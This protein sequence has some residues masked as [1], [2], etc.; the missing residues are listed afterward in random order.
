MTA[1]SRPRLPAAVVTQALI[2]GSLAGKAGVAHF[3][4]GEGKRRLACLRAL[5]ADFDV[6]ARTL[7]PIHVDRS[8]PLLEEA[9][10]LAGAGAAG[11][12]DTVEDDLPRWLTLYRDLDG[13][14]SRLIVATDAHTEGAEPDQLR[15]NVAACLRE[16]VLPPE[17]VLPVVT[18]NPASA[19][20]LPRK[21]RLAPGAD[22]DVLVVAPTTLD[23]VHVFARGRQVMRDGL[24]GP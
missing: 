3:H 7:F 10:A 21:G 22:A 9:V 19:L 24:V 1:A 14:L 2:G 16:R 5:I 20:G 18:R 4:V 11:S 6:P 8:R 15:R 12:M 17:R 13:A 23:V